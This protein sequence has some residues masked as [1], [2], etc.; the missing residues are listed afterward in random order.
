MAHSEATRERAQAGG[1]TELVASIDQLTG[2]DGVV[3]ATPTATHAEV[4]SEALALAVPV[5]VEKPLASDPEAAE[6]LAEEADG[7]LFVMDKWRYHPGIEALAEIARGGEL[8]RPR[9]LELL[10]LGWGHPHL[11]VDPIWIL[12]P[13]DLS[14][15]LELLGELPAPKSASAELMNGTPTGLTGQLGDDPW[16]WLSCSAAAPSKRREARL[17]CEEGVAALSDGWADSIQ[18]SRDPLGGQEPEHRRVSAELPLLRELR[19][20]VEHLDGGP[21]PRSSARE[22]AA[23]VRSISEL[24]ALAGI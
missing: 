4:V 16:V 9:S 1:A 11:D 19:A 5:Y 22:G 3:V 8:G 23:I 10:R 13:H 24:R 18:V 2:V 21:P 6:R 7:R 15:A 20:F 17:V 14:I 12:A